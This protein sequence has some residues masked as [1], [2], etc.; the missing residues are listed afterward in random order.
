MVILKSNLISILDPASPLNWL[1]GLDTRPFDQE[2]VEE[3]SAL[4]DSE[5]SQNLALEEAVAAEKENFNKVKK[6]KI[7]QNLKIFELSGRSL[8]GQWET[9]I[10]GGFNKGWKTFTKE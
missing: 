1:L 4:Y 10:K 3:L 5:K 8:V 9:A 6:H 2:E 7:L